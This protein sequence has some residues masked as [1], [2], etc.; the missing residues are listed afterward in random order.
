MKLSLHMMVMNGAAVLERALR[1]LA[2]IIDEI[3]FTD[4]GSTDDTP[5]VIDSLSRQL[6]FECKGV[7]LTLQTHPERYF[8]DE[9]NS[10]KHRFP[11]NTVFTGLPQL[12]DW[13]YARNLSLELCTG[14]YILRIDADD[15]VMRPDNILPALAMLDTRPE[16]DFLMC[17][18][19][20]MAGSKIDYVTSHHFFWRNKPEHR[21]RY[22]L[23]E[24]VPGRRV[25]GSNWLVAQRGL[26]FRDWRDCPGTGV[27]VPHR[28]FKVL[29]LE[30]ER[31]VASGRPVPSHITITLADEGVDVD[32]EFA[33]SLVPDALAFPEALGWVHYIRGAC[34]E[35]LGRRE[36]ALVSYVLAGE[37][38]ELRG[39]LRSG[40]MRHELGMPGHRE[41]LMSALH[42]RQVAASC[43]IANTDVE[44]V[45]RLL[46]A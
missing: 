21:F 42:K 45:T 38:Q 12:C 33:L 35:K 43:L 4:T 40:L 19:E 32:P 22:V 6:H 27:R 39:L 9:P 8:I 18:Y 24:H 20:V 15:E 37:A 36:E 14:Q 3:C 16:V 7:L 30:H 31:L 23:H 28:N 29:L 44:R 1:P 26:L 13:S 17:M 25:D 11:S 2:G 41:I 5:K 10:F 46:Q 34:L